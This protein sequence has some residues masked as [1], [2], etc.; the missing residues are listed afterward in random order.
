MSIDRLG[1]VLLVGLSAPLLAVAEDRSPSPA[2]PTAAGVAPGHPSA[3]AVTAKTKTR[4]KK[5]AKKGAR[6]KKK[7]AILKKEDEGA[8][9]PVEPLNTRGARLREKGEAFGG[10]KGDRLQEDAEKKAAQ[11]E[12]DKNEKDKKSAGALKK[13]GASPHHHAERK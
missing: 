6:P 1:V 12:K 2:A 9:K 3:P 7:G 8:Q 5:G 11:G 13:P 4:G 10:G